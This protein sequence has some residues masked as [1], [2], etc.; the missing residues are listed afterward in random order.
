MVAATGSLTLPANGQGD[1][2]LN[3]T[4][5]VGYKAILAV[6][7]RCGSWAWMFSTCVLRSQSEVYAAIKSVL[8]AQET[9]D[10]SAAVLCVRNL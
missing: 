6:P 5:P 4:L 9:H 2:V 10:I 7:T 1:V 3:F 8:T